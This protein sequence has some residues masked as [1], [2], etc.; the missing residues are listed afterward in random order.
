MRTYTTHITA[1]STVFFA[2]DSTGK[3]KDE[4]TGFSYVG[5]RYMDHELMTSWLSVDPMADKYP[6]ISPY[7]YCAWNPIKLVDPNGEEWDP[8][9][10]GVVDEFRQVTV[11]EMNNAETNE[12]RLKYK[13]VLDE[14]SELDLSSQVYH[15]EKNLGRNGHISYDLSNDW[16][17]IQ[18]DGKNHNLAHELKH[19][20]QFEKSE[21]SF[22]TET[23][24]WSDIVC[25]E[26]GQC[27]NR[28]LLYDL[29]DEVA[30]YQR[31]ELYGGAK[32]TDKYIAN[33]YSFEIEGSNR[34]CYPF[35]REPTHSSNNI[36]LGCDT[37]M[38][39]PSNANPDRSALKGNIFRLNGKTYKK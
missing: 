22:S 5:A 16:V 38:S 8:A 36:Y 4:E 12:M 32:V 29:T 1:P 34:R 19:A 13:Q 18:F 20:Y 7:A 23:G 24:G 14:L 35:L 3:E 31:G 27:M 37:K 25:D 26:S 15:V 6:T 9:S 30:A 17:S 28:V 10:K 39:L 33:R 21:L 2:S 11:N